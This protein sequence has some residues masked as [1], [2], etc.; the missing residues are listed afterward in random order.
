MERTSLWVVARKAVAQ[1]GGDAWV[2]V[3]SEVVPSL[4]AD[5]ISITR[6]VMARGIPASLAASADFEA[7]ESCVG[8]LVMEMAD[9]LKQAGSEEGVPD[10]ALCGRRDEALHALVE[11]GKELH[12]VWGDAEIANVRERLRQVQTE[13]LD[14][15]QVIHVALGG[16]DAVPLSTQ[17]ADE[18]L[19]TLLERY[20]GWVLQQ[21]ANAREGRERTEKAMSDLAESLRLFADVLAKHEAGAEL[22]ASEAKVEL[23]AAELLRQDSLL[24]E[25]A[26]E[27]ATAVQHLTLSASAALVAK[28]KSEERTLQQVLAAWERAARVAEMGE[29][30]RTRLLEQLNDLTVRHEAADDAFTDAQHELEKLQK[31]KKRGK[32]VE[33]LQLTTKQK[34]AQ[35]RTDMSVVR[36]EMRQA[37]MEV[38][39]LAASFY[40]ELPLQVMAQYPSLLEGLHSAGGG[41]LYC[42]CSR[43]EHFGDL[44]RLSTAGIE[45]RHNVWKGVTREGGED[46]AVVLKQYDLGS[47]TDEERRSRTRKMQREV[48]SLAKLKHPN[49]I[50]VESFFLQQDDTTNLLCC[51]VRF[52]WYAG[53]DF[54]RWLETDEAGD[55]SKVQ[56]LVWDVLRGL[57]HVHYHEI[58]HGDVKAGNVLLTEVKSNGLRRAVLADFDLSLDQRQRQQQPSLMAS[59]SMLQQGPRGTPGVLTLAPEVMAGGEASMASD[60]FSFGGLALQALYREQA[61]AWQALSAGALWDARGEACCLEGVAVLVRRL[62]SRHPP[63][64]PSA[65]QALADDMFAAMGVAEHKEAARQLAALLQEQQRFREEEAALAAAVQAQMKDVEAQRQ[66]VDTKA[67]SLTEQ[68]RQHEDQLRQ[69]REALQQRAKLLAGPAHPVCACE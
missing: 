37:W 22:P 29:K 46:V 56:L 16:R 21:Q 23:L 9:A 59:A 55:A 20:D 3:E 51:Y 28:L 45:S 40:P 49:V 39:A 36:S 1:Q 43:L 10:A 15:A 57:E 4:H 62:L 6:S 33:E 12:R 25:A 41:K 42:P 2:S 64:R 18:V 48:H 52:A 53:G 47:T 60:M 30:A 11:R 31:S 13:L 27:Y 14:K 5:L 65:S 38:H 68:K 35:A 24:Q 17:D 63:Q 34:L 26:R 32:D 54:A 66:A 19:A 8:A 67:A 69:Q 44:Q 58:V 7:A 50:Q 61:Q